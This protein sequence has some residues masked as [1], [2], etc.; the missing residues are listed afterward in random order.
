MNLEFFAQMLE[1]DNLKSK[2]LTHQSQIQSNS[3]RV[4]TV[5]KFRVQSAEE[6]TRLKKN[7]EDTHHHFL[8]QEKELHKV[9][10]LLTRSSERQSQASTSQECAAVEQE[11]KLFSAQKDKLE[12]ELFDVLETEEKLKKSIN[13]KTQFLEGSEKSL[14][15]IKDEVIALNNKE[16]DEIKKIQER[17]QLY[18]N[19]L[20]P[21]G[22][23]I[24]TDLCKRFPKENAITFLQNGTCQNCRS[25]VGRNLE[26]Q[27]E[28]GT[29]IEHCSQ[30]KRLLSP[31]KRV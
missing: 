4:S 9:E 27:I 31:L 22:K 16:E 17:M 2:I 21:T 7:L 29:I 18:I 20:S 11:M 13:E 12:N 15:Q 5:E 23:S 25:H 3:N 10:Q 26:S 24:W 19:E 8:Q 6:L 14:L 30:C 1:L 28:K